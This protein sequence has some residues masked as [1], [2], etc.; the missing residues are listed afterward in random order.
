MPNDLTA[1]PT[2][3]HWLTIAEAARLIERRQ[4]S[5][6]ELTDALIARVEALDPQLH[7]FLLPTPEK[8]REQ[9]RTAERDIMAGRYRGQ[10]HGIP[11]GLKDIYATA[12]IR[13]T[14][15]SKICE[16]L[17]PTEDATTV[18]KLYQAGMVLL[19][20]L[21]THEFAH[22][23]PSFDLPWPPARNPWDRDHFTGGSSS[24]AGAAVAAG[25]VPA[26]L[27]SDTG[28]SIRGP[29]ALCGIVGLKPTYG[30]VSRAGVYANSFTFDHAGPMTWT[31][32][33]CAIML[34]GIAGHDSKDP[35]SADRA[36]PDYRAALTGDIRG[37][38]I[39]IVRHLYE[40][41]IA[42]APE[43][44]AALEEAYAVFRSLGATLEDVRI[45]PA[46]DYYAV[47]ITIAESEQYAIHE[48]ELRTR[49]SDFGADFL[50][51]AL[52]AVLYSGTDYVQAQRERRLMLAEMA[53]IYE[54]YDL[55][56]TPT[57]PGPAPR[58]GT[59]RTISFWQ[60]S[61]LTTPFNVTAGPALAQCMGFTPAGLPLSLQIV[62]RPFDE[63]TVLR[64]AHAYEMATNW[65]SHRPTLDPGASFSNEP[66][67]SVRPEPVSDPAT[68]D[69]VVGA[70]R[71]AE[72]SLN[73]GQLD[74]IC[75]AAPYVMAM[76]RRLRRERN[77]REE[78]ANIFQFPD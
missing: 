55:L 50:G 45:R 26:A 54:K 29:A 49:P 40:D 73:D 53:P 9:A 37:L 27:G 19:G 77:F 4:L 63:A 20:K 66:P 47:K 10:L 46:A 75:A 12:G 72:L 21:A 36:I 25:F 52:P 67:P 3:L 58:L 14:S 6:V 2:D 17:V 51:R 76:T 5:P 44:R 65:R 35:A 8:A 30:L 23:G 15:H 59:W 28:G 16:N 70:C 7:A 41:D 43:V 48:E 34:Q 74:M 31:V 22:G 64:A 13:T 11:V 78:P 39:G 33:D 60:N 24:G 61:S 68:R 38:R 1:A 62:G 42:V 69:M 71:R 18:T 56:L 57:A 32:E